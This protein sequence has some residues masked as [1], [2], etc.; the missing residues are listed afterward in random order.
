[1]WFRA[2]EIE[3]INWAGNPHEAV[4]LGFSLGALNPRKSFATCKETIRGRSRSWEAV[5]IES[6]QAFRSRAAFL[7]QRQ[8]YGN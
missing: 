4:E 5:D 1:M 8:G 7:L 6:V 3:E 2:E